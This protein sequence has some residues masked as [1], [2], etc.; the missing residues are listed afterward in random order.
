MEKG[1]KKHES[2]GRIPRM[3]FF[4]R[5]DRVIIVEN[6]SKIF[7]AKIGGRDGKTVGP[8]GAISNHSHSYR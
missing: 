1:D 6:S 4:P 2:H 8:L 7:C 5:V 3:S